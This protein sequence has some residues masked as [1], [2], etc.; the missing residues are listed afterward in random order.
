MSPEEARVHQQPHAR[1][2]NAGG[3]KHRHQNTAE[4]PSRAIPVLDGDVAGAP[5]GVQES[6]IDWEPRTE[7]QRTQYRKSIQRTR[8]DKRHKQQQASSGPAA[9]LDA[10]HKLQSFFRLLLTP[11]ASTAS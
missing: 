5:D 11:Q 3:A 1:I 2:G 6:G 8:N 7:Q 9:E 10:A 4:R